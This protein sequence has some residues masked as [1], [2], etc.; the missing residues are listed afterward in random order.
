MAPL[1]SKA[2]Q[3]CGDLLVA[4]LAYKDGDIGFT[5]RGSFYSHRSF[6][7]TEKALAYAAISVALAQ[8]APMRLVVIDELGRLTPDN[9]MRLI[10]KLCELTSSGQ[11]DQALLVDVT[12]IDGFAS[13]Q[14]KLIKL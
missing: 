4:P 5:D 10:A 1:I 11:L 12:P 9:K 2:N 6:S 13:T 14:F 7:G 3:L 8:D